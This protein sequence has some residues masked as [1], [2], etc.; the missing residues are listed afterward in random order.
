MR[1]DKVKSLFKGVL[2]P[3][4]IVTVPGSD[5]AEALV[6]PYTLRIVARF[7]FDNVLAAPPEP[8]F[9]VVGPS[10]IAGSSVR[11]EIDGDLPVPEKL[12]LDELNAR[13]LAPADSSYPSHSEIKSELENLL[14]FHGYT[15][16]SVSYPDTMVRLGVVMDSPRINDLMINGNKWIEEDYI[17]GLLLLGKDYYNAYELDSSIRKL[18]PEPA[19][20]TVNSRVVERADGDVDIH[21]DI[22][23]QKPY[24][25]LLATKFTDIDR[26]FGLVGAKYFDI[27]KSRDD[28]EYVFS[29]QEVHE[30]GGEV[31]AHYD[32]T[33]NISINFAVFGKKYRAPTIRQDLPV[34]RGTT[35]GLNVRFHVA[36]QL[37]LYGV[38]LFRWG[39]TFYHQRSGI[40]GHGDFDFETYQLNFS[41]ESK[42]FEHFSA[43][44]TFHVG[45]LTGEAPPQEWLSL[46]GMTTLPGYDDDAFVN[47]HL[48]LAGQSFYISAANWFDETSVWSPVRL[49]LSGHAGTVWGEGGKLRTEDLRMDAGFE[50]DYME[51]LRFG[52]VWPVGPLRGDSPRV[53]VGWGVHVF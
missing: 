17:R 26:Y 28:L 1:P 19:I 36:G 30:I 3:K 15:L 34:Q 41:G 42:P 37:P 12:I 4:E 24:R 48:F 25:I 9:K 53:Y 6:K 23:E 49:I 10:P 22:A 35:N 27:V 47:T 43:R 39:H 38:P 16:T 31:A 11:I 5:H 7:I 40:F 14:K 32:I 50:L 52:V 21:V 8:E 29:R 33:S 44:T 51:T 13:L 2:E 18:S 20:K 45:W 46:G